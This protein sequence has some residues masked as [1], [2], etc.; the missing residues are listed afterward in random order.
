MHVYQHV[1]IVTAFFNPHHYCKPISPL[2]YGLHIKEDFN[3]LR[4]YAFESKDY[5]V[6]GESPWNYALYLPSDE[7]AE[8]DL[9]VVTRGLQKG[10]LPFSYEGTP[11]MINAKVPCVHAITLY[12]S[13]KQ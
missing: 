11:V 9:E 1:L 6:T 7:K 10:Y 2:L 3:V 12:N 13:G 5:Q 4:S 8:E